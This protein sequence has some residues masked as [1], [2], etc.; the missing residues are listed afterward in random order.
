[1]RASRRAECKKIRAS[2]DKLTKETI[3]TRGNENLVSRGTESEI[4]HVSEDTFATESETTFT[5]VPARTSTT[6]FS[7]TLT[8]TFVTTTAK[9]FSNP[10]VTKCAGNPLMSSVT[11]ERKRKNENAV[12]NVFVNP[13][14]Q[15]KLLIN[16][17]SLS[18]EQSCHLP[19]CKMEDF[20]HNEN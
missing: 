18:Q 8:T 2:E 13:S 20:D 5:E 19:S 17:N 1:M 12:E 6:I 14:K 10:S 9:F 11:L 15:L 3:M 16:N 7:T 4:I